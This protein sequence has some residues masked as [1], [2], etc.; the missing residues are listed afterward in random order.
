MDGREGTPNEMDG[1]WACLR[2]KTAGCFSPEISGHVMREV[3][4]YLFIFKIYFPLL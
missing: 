1:E 2:K 3:R 4:I